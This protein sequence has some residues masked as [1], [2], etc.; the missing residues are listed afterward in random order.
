MNLLGK[1]V[2]LLLDPLLLL[3]LSDQA[4]RTSLLSIRL[5][6]SII[7]PAFQVAIIVS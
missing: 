4:V 6:L 5:D 7:W 2:G 1:L 3:R